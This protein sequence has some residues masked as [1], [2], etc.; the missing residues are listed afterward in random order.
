MVKRSRRARRRSRPRRCRPATVIHRRR[1]A[2]HVQGCRP[3]GQLIRR[4][5]TAR[6]G[7]AVAAR[8]AGFCTPPGVHQVAMAPALNSRYARPRSSSRRARPGNILPDVGGASIRM[9]WTEIRAHRAPNPPPHQGHRWLPAGFSVHT[10]KGVGLQ[11]SV[12]PP[13]SAHGPRQSS[14][15]F[16]PFSSGTAARSP[17][18][19]GVVSDDG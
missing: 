4:R 16:R 10:A 12:V 6:F 8:R 19:Y 2:A 13:Q 7:G 18:L 17:P 9:S 15:R 5:H 3:I 11:R 14:T 1:A